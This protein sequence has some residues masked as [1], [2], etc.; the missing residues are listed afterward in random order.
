MKPIHPKEEIQIVIKRFFE[1]IVLW[2]Y[3]RDRHGKSAAGQGLPEKVSA[4][5]RQDAARK[6]QSEERQ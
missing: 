4:V 3:L 1:R 6:K 5:G 2:F